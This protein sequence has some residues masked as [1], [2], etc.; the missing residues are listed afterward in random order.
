MSNKINVISM[1]L[2]ETRDAEFPNQGN[3]ERKKRN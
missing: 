1:K 3:Q 2:L